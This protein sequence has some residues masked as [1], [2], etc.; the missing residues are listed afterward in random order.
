[1]EQPELSTFAALRAR[2]LPLP[3]GNLTSYTLPEMSADMGLKLSFV[4]E[5]ASAP[6]LQGQASSV[7]FSNF[8]MAGV[9]T[10]SN[11]LLKATMGEIRRFLGIALRNTASMQLDAALL[12]NQDGIIGVRPASINFGAEVRPS[13]GIDIP[14]VISDLRCLRDKLSAE[15]AQDP[16]V[17]MHPDQV[18][19]LRYMRDE[20]GWVFRSEID[21]GQ[22]LGM[23]VISRRSVPQGEVI[24]LDASAF[25]SWAGMPQIDVSNSA[26]L[27]MVNADDTAPAMN[28][29]GS[30]DAVTDESSLDV[31]DAAGTTPASEVRSLLQTNAQALRIISPVTFGMARQ[32]GVYQL[33]PVEW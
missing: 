4:G 3:M 2:G 27:V 16:V 21:A 11:E 19:A 25:A 32:R 12:G 13:S 9:V 7:N 24:A 14:S 26:T 5:S 17:L 28:P 10:F 30:P 33:G 23:D 15:K 1:M 31:S 29:S 22:I 18:T 8:K 20:A 6:V